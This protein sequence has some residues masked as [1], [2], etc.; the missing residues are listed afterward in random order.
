[1]KTHICQHCK[2]IW[3]QI[4]NQLS[5]PN[6]GMKSNDTAMTEESSIHF[7]LIQSHG[8]WSIE[9][10]GKRGNLKQY[11]KVSW[12]EKPHSEVIHK[13]LSLYISQWLEE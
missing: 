13:T 3:T 5:C 10:R 12:S 11:E 4:H 6:C 2:S 9:C 8:L 1:M 7:R